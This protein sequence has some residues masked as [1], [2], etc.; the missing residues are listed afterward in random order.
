[1]AKKCWI[2]YGQGFNGYW[3]ESLL[4]AESVSYQ[5]TE[6]NPYTGQ[7]AEQEIIDGVP[8]PWGFVAPGTGTAFIVS[9]PIQD[10]YCP[11]PRA[12]RVGSCNDCQPPQPSPGA[13]YDKINGVCVPASTY[14]TAGIYQSLEECQASFSSEGCP[15]GWEC[16]NVEDTQKLRDCLC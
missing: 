11:N 7:P 6:T 9:H 10:Q 13:K 8:S 2:S 15:E 14:N 16:V 5:S 1:M 4:C 12:Q 3:Y